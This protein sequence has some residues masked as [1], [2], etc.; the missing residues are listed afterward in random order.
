MHRRGR[1]SQGIAAGKTLMMTIESLLG[2]IHAAGIRLWI[3][4]GQLRYRAPKAMVPPELLEQ[5]RNRR[6]ELIEILKQTQRHE[7][8]TLPLVPRSLRTP[9]AASFAQERLWFLMLNT[10]LFNIDRRR[11]QQLYLSHMCGFTSGRKS[12][13]P[14]V[15]PAE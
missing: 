11:S 13:R 7:A 15:A 2:A 4:D 3:D 9:V 14:N 10:R 8:D 6:S 1:C 5:I 12:L